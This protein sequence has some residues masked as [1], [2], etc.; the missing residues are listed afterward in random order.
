MVAALLAAGPRAVRLQKA[1]MR[2]WENVPVDRA[3]AAGIDSF[4]RAF[5]TDEPNRLL[6]AFLNRKR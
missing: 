1:L 3:V 6:G 5:D 2:E 4:A